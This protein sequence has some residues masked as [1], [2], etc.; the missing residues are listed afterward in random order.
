MASEGVRPPA[1]GRGL[2][3]T[4]EQ[5]MEIACRKAAEAAVDFIIQIASEYAETDKEASMAELQAILLGHRQ[6]VV[7]GAQ[8]RA[9]QAAAEELEPGLFAAK[10]KDGD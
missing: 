3:R 1:R 5:K 9:F 7:L 2:K 4:M 6:S 8:E 10:G